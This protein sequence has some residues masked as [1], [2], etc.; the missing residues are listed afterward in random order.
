M[1]GQSVTW[2][3]WAGAGGASVPVL[4]LLFYALRRAKGIVEMYLKAH[5]EARAERERRATMVAMAASLP[6][7]GAAARFEA[8]Q[9][10]WLFCKHAEPG[11]QVIVS[12]EAA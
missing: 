9:P 11:H 12:R 8:G 6:E 1:G 10:A 2:L 4:L 3:E 7:G 5:L